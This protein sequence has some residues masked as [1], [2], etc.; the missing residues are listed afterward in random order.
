[1]VSWDGHLQE[2]V[3][4]DMRCHCRPDGGAYDKE[5]AAVDEADPTSFGDTLYGISIGSEGMY[6]GTYN[7]DE[8]LGWISD[9]QKSYPDTQLGT[10]DSWNCWN[11][12]SM[13]AIINSGIQLM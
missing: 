13:D 8:L 4:A 6:R 2:K 7:G 11:N 3:G 5:K 9:M 10:A 1:V 12:G